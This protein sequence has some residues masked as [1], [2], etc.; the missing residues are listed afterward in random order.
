[1]AI[2]ISGA[3]VIPNT[4]GSANQVLKINAGGSAGEWG[5]AV[6]GIT[7][8]AKTANY[9]A[10]TDE[11]VVTDT[12]G[13]VFTVTLPASPSEGDLVVIADGAGT[14]DTNNLTVARNGETID[15][16]AEDLVMN[17]EGAKVDFIYD[18]ADWNV[19][20]KTGFV[21]V[22]SAFSETEFTATA[23]QTT[24]TVAYTAGLVSVY[25]NG[26]RL[27]AADYTAT[28]GTSV[29]LATGATAGD[30]VEIVAW[31]AF[32]VANAATAGQGSLADSA[33]QPADSFDAANLTG[34]AAAINGSNI[35][36]LAAANLTGALPA[37]DGSSLTGIQTGPT[38]GTPVATTSGTS[39]DFTGIP[40]GV[41]EIKVY[42]SGVSEAAN[43]SYIVQLGNSGGFVT[44]GYA[45]SGFYLA[46]AVQYE[47]HSTEG[48]FIY[49][50]SAGHVISGTM[51]IN[52][53][54]EGGH[55]WAQSSLFGGTSSTIGGGG[56]VNISSEL[57][58]LRFKTTSGSAF[59]AGS[60]N[61]SWSF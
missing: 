5:D 3:T 39:V 54:T 16:A 61:I 11:G 21:T 52:R 56:G 53:T 25:L 13:G 18:G 12:S 28:N 8:V 33:V 59:D 36:N 60:I 29:V 55:G 23:S 37:I 26:V 10:N 9:T 58:Q 31:S 44:S 27:A 42:L 20:S 6:G 7:Y 24:F 15:G 17:V 51:T 57:T 22:A 45:S 50:Q 30:L 40:A 1:M 2:K 14:W 46:A 34:T 43:N 47:L 49:A 38:Y 32:D 35:A 19:F 41:K 4:L 48:L